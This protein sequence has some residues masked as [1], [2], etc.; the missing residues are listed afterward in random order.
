MSIFVAFI[1]LWMGVAQPF[2]TS[3]C[4]YYCSSASQSTKYEAIE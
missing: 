2:D 1:E 3:T 4:L